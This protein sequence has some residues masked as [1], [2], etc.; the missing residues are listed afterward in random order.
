MRLLSRSLPI[1]WPWRPQLGLMLSDI[2]GSHTKE[3]QDGAVKAPKSTSQSVQCRPFHGGMLPVASLGQIVLV[4]AFAA[5]SYLAVG[6][7]RFAAH[8]N[9]AP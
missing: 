7:R 9:G 2:R 5:S 4:E 8:G 3:A 6:A 1:C